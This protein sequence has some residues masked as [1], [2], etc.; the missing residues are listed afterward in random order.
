LVSR[1]TTYVADALNGYEHVLSPPRMIMDVAFHLNAALLRE[2]KAQGGSSRRSIAAVNTSVEEGALCD[3][4]GGALL[5]QDAFI[6]NNIGRNDTLIVSVGGND[7][8]LKPSVKTGLSALA[9]SRMASKESIEAGRAVGQSHFHKLF[10]DET[11]RYIEKLICKTKP[12]R[13]LVCTLYFLDEAETGSWADTTLGYLGYNSDPS[14][15]QAQIRYVFQT[16]TS[17]IEL[18]GVE[19]VPVPLFEALD[20]KTSADYKER[21]EPSV[22]GGAK[23]AELLARHVL[24]G[25]AP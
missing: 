25:E 6:R 5:E 21:V 8:A 12:R 11:K 16:A 13:V 2:L 19:V 14:R 17:T 3:R 15:L 10:H 9:M 7:V 20:G 23:M 1:H 4:S 22:T 18:D 24:A